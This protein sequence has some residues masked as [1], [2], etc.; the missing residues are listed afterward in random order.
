MPRD[1]LE[2]L[3]WEELQELLPSGRVHLLLGNGFS[4][5][6]D[7]VFQYESLFEKA[8]ESG[9]STR[10][11]AVFERLGSNNFEGAMRLLDDTHWVARQYGLVEGDES[12][13]L[14]DVEHLKDALIRAI[15]DSHLNH[16]GEVPDS[17]KRHALAIL[18]SFYNIFT[19]NYDL[20]LYWVIMVDDA[21]A[22]EDGFRADPEDA[23]SAYLVFHERMGGR[24]GVYYI[25]GALHLYRDSGELRKHSWARSGGE[26]LTDQIREGLASQRY[27]VFVAEGSPEK[28]LQQIRGD[29]Y[30]SYCLGKLG[31]ISN[32]LVV[33]GH[34]LGQADRHVLDTIAAN[35]DLNRVHI[36]LYEGLDKPENLH[37]IASAEYMKDRRTALVPGGRPLEITFFDSSTVG[38][39]LD[40]AETD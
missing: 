11:Q 13:I 7:P 10:A 25:H 6:C 8:V 3:D 27:P 16:A 5:S 38:M 28:K 17:K 24:Q 26:R 20:L 39:W 4:I 23:E 14:E 2:I 1:D 32:D 19:V 18:S 33:F 37:T 30:L 9:L 21:P 29:A 12:E 31:R 40:E 36:G 35:R 34:S 22:Y 15:S